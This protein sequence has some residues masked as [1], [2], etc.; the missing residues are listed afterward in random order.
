[1]KVPLLFFVAAATGHR[2]PLQ[3]GPPVHVGSATTNVSCTMAFSAG[4][5]LSDSTSCDAGACPYCGRGCSN[6][7]APQW[8]HRVGGALLL[9]TTTANDTMQT[10][11]PGVMYLSTSSGRTWRPLPQQPEVQGMV[12][13]RPGG[14]LEVPYR[15]IACPEDEQRLRAGGTARRACANA[16]RYRLEE[17]GRGLTAVGWELVRF[18]G[19]PF[20]IA[21]LCWPDGQI[22]AAGADWRRCNRE[23]D[24]SVSDA[25][26]LALQVAA[27]PTPLRLK[28]GGLHA[29][30]HADSICDNNSSC[31]PYRWAAAFTS[32]G[33]GTRWRWLSM[34]SQSGDGPYPDG[35][36]PNESDTV[37]LEDGSLL[38]V[39][40]SGDSKPT[41][42]NY[43][44]VRSTS[45]GRHWQAAEVVGAEGQRNAPH[46]VR[47]RLLRLGNGE[48]LLSGGRRGLF[49]WRLRTDGGWDATNIAAHH[50]AHYRTTATPELAFSSEGFARG[51]CGPGPVNA[52]F[53]RCW[54]QSSSYTSL[55]A[56]GNASAL[57]CYDKMAV[58]VGTPDM[59][60]CVPI[61]VP[62]SV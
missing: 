16:T 50:N 55:T 15:T 34:I 1:M 27:E 47:P 21:R 23:P 17:G 43:R 40:R 9:S 5:D 49:V 48:V 4:C 62:I 28:G 59:V 60:F 31:R 18:D 14:Y 29:T 54:R 19:L 10:S 2:Q 44:S 20:P 37:V 25:S 13:D 7:W 8:M 22:A 45:T 26:R 53:L 30:I 56:T 42:P 11:W 32:E 3:L 61:S 58:E 57:L 24:G 36:G 41:P 35:D 38:A 12:I 51:D 39:F 6:L 52:S 33:D 46:A